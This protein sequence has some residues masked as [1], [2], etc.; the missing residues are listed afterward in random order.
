MK[1]ETVPLWGRW[2][3]TFIATTGRDDPDPDTEFTVELASP[4]GKRKR[5]SGFWNGG[6]EWRVRFMPD[7]E[8]KWQ[9]HTR[10]ESSLPGLNDVSGTFICRGMRGKTPFAR[11]GA[12][13][14]SADGHYLQHAD[15]TPFFWLGDTVWTGPTLCKSLDDWLFY[16]AERA[17]KKYSVTQFNTMAP[18][19]TAP[20][21]IEGQAAFEGREKV[22]INPAYFQRL[23]RYVDAI[24]DRGMLAAPVLIWSLTDKDPGRYLSEEDCIRLARYQIARY[25]GH[26]VLW[27]LAGDNPYNSQA[28]EKWK[29]VGRAVFG[30]SDSSIPVTTHPTGENW[31]WESWRNESWLTVLGYQSGH[32]DS[33]QSLRWLHSGPPHENWRK[34]PPRPI[35][36][37]EPPY[38]GH[39]GYES[40]KPH[41]DYSV[42][43]GVYWSLLG[44]R[45]AGVTYGGHGLWSWHTA[46]GQEPTDHK[47]SGIAPHWREALKRSGGTQMKHVVTLFTSLP[48]WTLRPANE[49]LTTQPGGDDPA[50]HVSVAQS[51]KGDT[52]LAYLPVG[53]DV[54]FRSEARTDPM[55]AEWF[56]PRTGRRRAAKVVKERSGVFTAPD[57]QDWV[58]VLRAPNT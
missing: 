24:N 5:I 38:E 31:P 3:Q 36:N 35:I 34:E 29:R 8:G 23:D 22:R 47:G 7:E 32:G 9:Y 45:T 19:R 46:E 25:Q 54:A 16:L 58:L 52:F 43:R 57:S 12:I 48:W 4:S 21:D 44:T 17:G 49:L 2:E 6:E 37:L 55:R 10:T 20:T 50:K 53:G 30:G 28:A 42:R 40:H 1:A 41:S 56:D 13:R 33:V 14:V 11:H 18:W 15:G 39:N 26:H 51:E 27:I